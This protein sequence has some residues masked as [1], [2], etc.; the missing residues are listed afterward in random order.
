M[1]RLYDEAHKAKLSA[2]A[3]VAQRLE[4]ARKRNPKDS[5]K[6]F[7][8]TIQYY[9]DESN[10]LYISK[11]E[12]GLTRSSEEIFGI[13]ERARQI[14]S[15]DADYLKTLESKYV[16]PAINRARA[17]LEKAKIKGIDVLQKKIL[18]NSRKQNEAFIKRWNTKERNLKNGDIVKLFNDRGACLAGVIIDDKVRPGVV[19]ISTGAWYDPE[20]P[21]K[22]N[23]LCK[24]GNPNVLTRDKGTSKL[25]QGTIAHSCL[26]DIEL[27]KNKRQVWLSRNR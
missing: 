3:E 23:T 26:I 6:A 8:E 19:Q 25:G 16:V 9:V 7:N 2:Q 11:K 17:R 1:T 14:F 13:D 24:H 20:D 10:K 4:D 22:I 5:T 27:C 21:K 12:K 15:G 18:K